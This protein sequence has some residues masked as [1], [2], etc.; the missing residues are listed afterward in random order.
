MEEYTFL[1]ST[2]FS[3]TKSCD[4]TDFTGCRGRGVCDVVIV[5][6]RFEGILEDKGDL[7]VYVRGESI[8][9]DSDLK[10]ETPNRCPK[11]INEEYLGG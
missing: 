11:G 7:D 9:E 6:K 1:A 4:C 2:T 10:S 5:F 3:D 8:S